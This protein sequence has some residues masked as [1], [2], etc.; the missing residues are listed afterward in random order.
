M[1]FIYRCFPR[2]WP[3]LLGILAPFGITYIFNLVVFVIV[4]VTVQ[5]HRNR[6]HGKMFKPK[7][8]MKT[9]VVTFVLAVMFGVGWIF[10]VLG[11]AGL[12]PV[13]SK[14]C[15]F[16]FIAVVGFQG[17]LIFLLQPCR[18]TDARDEWKSWLD[19]LTCHARLFQQHG[20]TSRGSQDRNVH[21][22]SQ[23]PTPGNDRGQRSGIISIE[24]RFGYKAHLSDGTSGAHA[25]NPMA[26][27][28][29][30]PANV[31]QFGLS[32]SYSSSKPQIPSEMDSST[33]LSGNQPHSD[34]VVFK[35]ELTN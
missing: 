3:F 6:I 10:G 11:S 30:N 27:E 7:N 24:K 9:I 34:S 25:N 1:S 15:Q 22:S 17:C 20:S 28:N 16:T 35:N 33:S 21:L 8:F 31:E 32:D 14:A 29:L 5:R 13:I 4:V 26:L 18:S 23:T 12:G 19:N 2:G